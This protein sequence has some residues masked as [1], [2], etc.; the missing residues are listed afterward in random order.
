[1][2]HKEAAKRFLTIKLSKEIVKHEKSAL[3]GY[4]E[5]QQ[6]HVFFLARQQA[7]TAHF[8]TQHHFL[9]NEYHRG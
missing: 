9:A 2:T 7:R 8:T 1:M 5:S 4:K 3:P 6:N